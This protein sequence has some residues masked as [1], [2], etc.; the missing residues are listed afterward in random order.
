VLATLHALDCHSTPSSA[1]VKN[2]RSHTFAPH[3]C[4]HC[5]ERESF[6]LLLLHFDPQPGTLLEY[7]DVCFCIFQMSKANYIHKVR[8]AQETLYISV[9]KTCHLMLYREIIAVY[10]Q[11]HTKQINTLCGQNVEL[12]NVK[13]GGTYERV[14]ISP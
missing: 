14:L 6:I 7:L 4:L 2:E 11:I 5:V 8:T 9:I 13:T 12:L 1:E 10:S 3:I